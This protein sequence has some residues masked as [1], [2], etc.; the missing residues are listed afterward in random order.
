MFGSNMLDVAIGM[1]FI[2]LL[3]SL[4]CSAANEVIEGWFKNR[5]L[6]LERGIRELL[7]PNTEAAQTGIVADLYRHPLL[8]G[9]Y[10]GTYNQFVGYRNICWLWRWPVR[11]LKGLKLPSYIPARN[12][13]LALM[14]TV[15]PASSEKTPAPAAP[16]GTA[17]PAAAGGPAP[18]PAPVNTLSGTAGATPPT[19]AAPGVVV[20]AASPAVPA[21]PLVVVHATAPAVPAAPHVVVN[22]AATAVPA[23]SPAPGPLQP[24]RDA[25][26]AIPNDQTRKALLALVDAAGNDVSK[27]RE[28]IETWFN[29]SMER[30]SSWYKRRS[31]LIIFIIG[32]AAAVALNADSVMLVKSLSTDKT[33]RDSLVASAEAY[34]KANNPPPTS[35][36]PSS[37]PAK[38]TA[39]QAKVSP[40][41]PLPAACDKDE[42]SP[43]C[44]LAKTLKEIRG[45][46]LPIGWVDAGVGA[47]QRRTWPGNHWRRDGGWWYQLYWHWLGWLITALAVSLGAPF[48][49]DL[50]NKFISVRSS[51]KPDEKSPE[52][53]ST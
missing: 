52:K 1:V 8:N 5:A 44:K 38:P 43:E 50:L 10:K 3:L 27:A 45:L 39:D 49:F 6:D 25:I 21:A 32:F 35:A 34:A 16:P 42:N 30:V 26:G 17:P 19:P 47:E 33:M 14:D 46:E 11:L 51:M 48:W 9:L 37:N 36:A 2:Y 41:S 20:N 18:P 23:S 53:G 28:N 40:P 13:A 31:Q 24:L 22:P 12:F 4:I 15:L 7:E 29:S